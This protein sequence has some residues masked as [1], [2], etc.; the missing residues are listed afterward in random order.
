M[1]PTPP[2]SGN[3]AP[4]GGAIFA[5]RG[6]RP[7]HRPRRPSPAIPPPIRGGAAIVSRAPARADDQQRHDDGQHG[8][9][10]L[11]RRSSHLPRQHDGRIVD[12][13]RKHVHR[14]RCGLPTDG[15]GASSP[16]T[17]R[18]NS[19]TRSSPAI[20]RPTSRAFPVGGLFNTSFDLIG[21]SQNATVVETVPGSNLAPGT[22]PLLGALSDNGGP[23]E[24]MLPGSASVINKGA[25]LLP[26][27]ARGLAR[28][29]VYPSIPSSSAAGA[30]GAD[31]GAVEV[32]AGEG[33]TGP[34]LAPTGRRPSR[35]DPPGRLSP[36]DPQA[37]RC[38]RVRPGPPGRRRRS[39]RATTSRSA[40]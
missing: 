34:A 17:R 38:R 2:S 10:G 28:P 36:R 33:P 15:L 1:W 5:A 27:D 39:R 35:R 12:D 16:P 23:V 4:R 14:F 21:N 13:H 9:G 30:N 29:F 37:R 32:Q 24:T 8:G 7:D 20:R 3:S 11:G 19:T 22:N 26:T 25:S 40:R 6:R 18:S 31:L